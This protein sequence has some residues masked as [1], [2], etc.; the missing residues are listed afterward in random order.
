MQLVRLGIRW[1]I[2]AGFGSLLAL[3]LVLAGI[4]LWA[5]FRVHSDVTLMDAA[6]DHV[7]VLQGVS[8]DIA[9]MRSK[10]QRDKFGEEDSAI[11]RQASQDAREHLKVA[12]QTR[13]LERRKMY[14][15]LIDE[16]T[17][18]ETE[19]NEWAGLAA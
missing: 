18:F 13:T 1:R 16:V 15:G 11:A 19:R 14:Q 9:I 3:G 12:T 4:A 10:V 8:R 5:L 2:Y 7:A 17:T 6:A